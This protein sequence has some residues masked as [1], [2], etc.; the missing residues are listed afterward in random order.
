[1]ILV[2]GS[3]GHIGNVLVR[4]LLSTGERVRA[5]VL[6]GEDLDSIK[7]L[8]VEQVEGNVLDSTSLDRAMAG[9]GVV[10]HLAG[11]IS[12]LPGDETK[13]RRVNV[14]GTR[15][16]T[17]AALKAGVRRLVHTSSVHAFQ[18]LPHGTIVDETTPLV[19]D[20]SKNAYDKTKAM[21]TMAV[22]DAVKQGLDAVI[23]CPSGVIGPF[24]F[25][26]SEMGQ[27]ITDFARNKPHIL[28]DGAYDFVDVR[29]VARG[30]I[31]AEKRGRTGELYILSGAQAQLTQIRNTVQ[32]IVGMRMPTIILP[33][34]LAGFFARLMERIYRIT[35]NTPRFTSYALQT[36]RD[37]SAFSHAKAE[38]ELGYSSRALRDSLADTV[39]W[40]RAYE[41]G[42]ESAN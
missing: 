38:R 29:D 40:W 3:T 34:G 25:N 1:M 11:V 12:I 32:E 15:N 13:M 21:G 7:G 19:P 16:V 26:R 24:D 30:L 6:P 18:R 9:V 33:F 36:V 5:M 23:A 20:S 14:E 37:N 31:L 2:T 42:T 10:Y 22:L 39:A 35:Q 28:V 4:E 17:Q 41:A 27:T 8:Q